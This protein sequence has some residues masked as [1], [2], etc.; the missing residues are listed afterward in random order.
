[1][2]RITVLTLA[3]RDVVHDSGFGQRE[4][5]TEN[6]LKLLPV[7][8]ARVAARAEPIV[9]SPRGMLKDDFAPLEV[10]T[11]TRVL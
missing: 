2:W 11:D 7:D 4:L 9:S 5:L 3:R 10:A 1:M 8:V 6:T